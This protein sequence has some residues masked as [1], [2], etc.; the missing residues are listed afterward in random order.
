[1]T[2]IVGVLNKHGVALAADSAVTF[3]NT[4]K[5]VNTGNKVFALSKYQ[6][7]AIATYGRSAF[8]GTPWDIIIKLYRK[9][10]GKHSF[11]KLDDYID[12]FIKY[13]HDQKFF[14]EVLTQ[15]RYL[16]D[17]ILDFYNKVER[18]AMECPDFKEENATSFVLQ[19]L[20][21]CLS[22]NKAAGTVLCPEFVDY[23]LELF[24]LFSESYFYYLR[25]VLETI[26]STG[27]VFFGYGDTEIYPSLYPL[28]VSFGI[29]DRLHY[30]RGTPTIIQ[31][32]GT[33]ASVIPFAQIDVS[34]TI[35]RGI[36][37]SLCFSSVRYFFVPRT[38]LISEEAKASFYDVLAATFKDSL[39]GF[40]NQIAGII[41]PI[42]A[43]AS[44]AI[45]KLNLD[46]VTSNFIESTKKQF[47]EKYTDSLLDT[48]VSLDKE[49]MSNMAESFVSL[50]SLVRRMSP[51]EETVGGPVDV[52]F[53][54]K[55]DGLIWMKRKHYFKPELNNQFFTNYY[56]DYQENE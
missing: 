17:N 18:Q 6:P 4:H 38:S 32:N 22:L 1:M 34:Q 49:D 23:K 12:D 29:E 10:L 56:N 48:I 43:T 36:N 47:M 54:S 25:I 7:V 37:P 53:V 31:E 55:G 24:K 21:E 5:V 33:V 11:P 3:G 14:A 16:R 46:A 35:I 39:S 19:K 44:D 50:T 20:N 42:N 2:A 28:A 41:K 9:K 51:G 45:R 52:V 26:D 27:L 30:Y 40:A 15:H 13:L 8:M